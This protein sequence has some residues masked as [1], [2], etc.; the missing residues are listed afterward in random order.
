MIEKREIRLHGHRVMVRTCGEPGDGRP[1][2]LVVHGIAGSS[3]TWRSV[4][5]ALAERYTVVAPDLLGHGRSDKPA[6]DYSLGAHANLLRDV[7]VTLD[8]ER[9]TVIGHSLGGGVAMQLAYQHPER[10]ERLV[11]VSSGG[12]GPEVSWLLRALTL[13]GA[14]YLMPVLVPPIVR[15]AGNAIGRRLRRFGYDAPRVEQEWAAF[16]SLAEAGN[17]LSFVRTL[18]AVVGPGGQTVSA[19]DKLYLAQ[20][21]PTLIVWGE[22]DRMIPV[23]HA[24]AAHEALPGSRLVLFEGAGHFPHAEEPHRFVEVLTDFV[25][26]TEPSTLDAAAWRRLVAGGPPAA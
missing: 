25:D 10:C 2:L 26:T 19:L 14:E 22:R 7:L 1:V 9:A 24:H 17:R 3:A 16:S 18:R 11:L 23:R 13:P 6:Q 4:L 20:H 5:P 21:L 12:L 8:V 15:D